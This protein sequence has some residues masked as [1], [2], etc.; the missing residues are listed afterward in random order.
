MCFDCTI[1]FRIRKSAPTANEPGHA[2]A[3]QIC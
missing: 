1:V 2:D 3:N